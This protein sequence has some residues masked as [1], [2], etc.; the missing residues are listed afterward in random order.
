MDFIYPGNINFV[1]KKCG[2]CCGDTKQKARHILILETEAKKIA[3]QTTFLLT[4]FSEQING[5][6]PYSYEMKKTQE[7]KCFFLRE[8][9]CTI[10]SLRPLICRF[11]PFELK[12]DKES[13]THIFD[14]TIECPGINAGKKYNQKD[15]E[16]LFKLA[17]KS[18]FK[19]V[20]ERQPAPK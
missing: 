19:V 6:L 18:L 20:E 8:N 9:Q 13:N 12:F 5:K 7:G 11:Y 3:S 15:F 16:K 4:D 10:Y 17:K 14:F 2:L 1:C